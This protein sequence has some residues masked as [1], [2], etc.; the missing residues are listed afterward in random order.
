MTS[1]SNNLLAEVSDSTGASIPAIVPFGRAF[2]NEVIR[3]GVCAGS[4]V[5]VS[6]MLMLTVLV[7]F[8]ADPNPAPTP[9]PF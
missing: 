9:L 1:T 5:S 2:L 3:W 7:I 6:G 4:T 8:L